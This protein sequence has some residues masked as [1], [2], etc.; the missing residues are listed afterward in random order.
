MWRVLLAA[1]VFWTSLLAM[2]APQL[3]AATGDR[4]LYLYYTHTKE[5]ARITFRRNGKYDAG[6]L[7]ELN[8][9][10]RDWRRNKPTKMDPA[11]FDLIWE[12][13]QESG[14]SKPIH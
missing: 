1:T 8:N 6:G 11:L 4:S 7:A 3:A 2:A 9:F 13:Y 5:T 12:V 10:L 14:A